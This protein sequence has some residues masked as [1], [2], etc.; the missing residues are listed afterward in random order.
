MA[1]F[2]VGGSLGLQVSLKSGPQRH[3]DVQ[4]CPP[5]AAVATAFDLASYMEEKRV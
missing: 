1:F 5:P 2:L 4:R 3:L